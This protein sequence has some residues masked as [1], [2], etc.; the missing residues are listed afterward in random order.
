MTESKFR[1]FYEDSRLILFNSLKTFSSSIQKDCHKIE[2]QASKSPLR[3]LHGAKD[4][5][6]LVNK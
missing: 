1:H 6:N 2:F 3:I 4:V 5:K